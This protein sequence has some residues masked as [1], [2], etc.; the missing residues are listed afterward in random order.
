MAWYVV[1]YDLRGDEST[2]AYD[3]IGSALRTATDWCRPLFSHWIVESPLTATE[4]INRLLSVG[5]IDDD[6]GV[7]VLET[8]MRGQFHRIT[9]PA[10]D[11]LRQQVTII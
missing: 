5:A 2:D 4:I 6:D 11:W 8:T 7:I 3:R 9:S 10:V 1:S